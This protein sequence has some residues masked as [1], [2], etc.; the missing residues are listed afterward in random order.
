[1][2]KHLIMLKDFTNN[3]ERHIDL[4]VVEH[5][6]AVVV[7]ECVGWDVEVGYDEDLLDHQDPYG[8][9]ELVNGPGFWVLAH[10]EDYPVT[11]KVVHYIIIDGSEVEVTHKF[12]LVD[13]LNRVY[14]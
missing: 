5:T 2:K 1:M 8:S 7:K 10:V 14:F 4:E 9:V 3:D 13:G 12:T 11:I 6:P